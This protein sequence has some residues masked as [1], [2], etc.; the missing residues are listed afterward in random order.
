MVSTRGMFRGC[1][2][3]VGVG[4]STRGRC[5]GHYKG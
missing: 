5:S 3:G 4:V 1:L 2:Q